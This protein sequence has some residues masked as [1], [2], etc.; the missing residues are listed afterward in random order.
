MYCYESPVN[1]TDPSGHGFWC[2]DKGQ[3]FWDWFVQGYKAHQTSG[4]IWYDEINYWTL[5][6]PDAFKHYYDVGTKNPLSLEH[7]IAA[8]DICMFFIPEIKVEETLS[9]YSVKNVSGKVVSTI[10]TKADIALRKAYVGEVMAL[11]DIEKGMRLGGLNSET[12][13]RALHQTRRDIGVKYKELTSPEVLEQIYKRNVDKYGD[14]LGPTIDY[15]RA[16]GK[17]WEDI[18]DSA[19]RT[20]AEFN[21]MAGI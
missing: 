17:S 4:N 11:S 15:L 18:I 12:I 14:K 1:M 6:I 7:W 20:S 5:G 9:S 8:V 13:A 10:A 16:S 3:S 2:P 19:K 21:K